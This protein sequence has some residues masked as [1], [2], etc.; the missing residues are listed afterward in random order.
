MMMVSIKI[1]LRLCLFCGVLIP[2]HRTCAQDQ[3]KPTKPVANSLAVKAFASTVQPILNNCCASCHAKAEA[4]EGFRLGSILP[5]V[6]DPDAAAANAK[7]VLTQIDTQHP[8]AS[9]ILDYAA[10]PHGTLKHAALENTAP[11]FT[12]L[13]LWVH[14]AC[15]P[16]GTPRLSRLP[17]AQAVLASQ[18][19][20][21]TP[22]GPKTQFATLSATV[23]QVS[24]VAPSSDP[25]DPAVF[26]AAAHP[27]RR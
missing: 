5:N 11:A 17:V 9:A 22:T 21:F 16:E 7:V 27:Y 15:S 23:S 24:A 18:T 20:P 3:A 2:A 13:Q 19:R 8:A 12:Q 10:K 26:N 1:I 4:P 6:N 25:Y 14:W